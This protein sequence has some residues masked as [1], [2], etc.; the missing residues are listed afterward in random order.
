MFLGGNG[1][2]HVGPVGQIGAAHIELLRFDRLMP[3]GSLGGRPVA[4]SMS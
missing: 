1:K 4:A 3:K 2:G